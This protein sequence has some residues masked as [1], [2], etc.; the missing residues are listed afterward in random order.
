MNEKI[1]LGNL[2]NIGKRK[3]R[4]DTKIERRNQY[5]DTRKSGANY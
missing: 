1:F 2:F 5:N 3:N 4:K